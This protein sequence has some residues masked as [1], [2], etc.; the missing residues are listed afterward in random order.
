MD[1]TAV[2]DGTSTSVGGASVKIIFGISV[3]V[4]DFEVGGGV[5]SDV[6]DE[7]V[8]VVSED[9][10]QTFTNAV[11]PDLPLPQYPLYA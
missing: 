6:I 10:S 11:R 8:I 4:T 1:G 3:V 7:L 2:G 9:Q 5:V